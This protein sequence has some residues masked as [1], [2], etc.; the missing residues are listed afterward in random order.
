MTVCCP[1]CLE[2]GLGGQVPA[3]DE[4]STACPPAGRSGAVNDAATDSPLLSRLPALGEKIEDDSEI[5]NRFLDYVTTI[6]LDLYEAQ[7]EALLEI[8]AGHNVILSTPTGSGKSLVALAMHFKAMCEDKRSIYTSPVKALVNEKFFSLCEVFHPDNVGLMTGDASVNRDAPILCCTA[9]I[10]ANMALREGKD[11]DVQYVVM[12]EFHYYSDRDRGVAWQVPLLAMPQTRFLLMSATLGD[13]SFFEEALE[14]LNGHP[15]T[16]VTSEQRPVPLS[17][18]YLESPLHEVVP[19]L[20]ERDEAPVYLVNF[21]QKGCHT[22]AQNLM[23]VNF[24]SKEDKRAI[25][26]ALE[27]FRFDTPYGKALGR[28]IRHGVGLHHGGMLPKYRRLVERLAA[29]GLLKVI[30]GT[31][32]LGVG[33]NIPIRCVVL[34]K[35]CKFDG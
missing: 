24:T 17:F 33:V 22:E 18:E 35:L 34:T 15:T 28:F 16:T 8:V 21:T 20:I 13:M 6:G 25:A 2:L 26:K 3:R 29:R 31:D 10:L 4:A 27:G 23:S 32:T 12:D 7:E 14:A 9:E 11:A 19:W 30:S 1:S 5:F